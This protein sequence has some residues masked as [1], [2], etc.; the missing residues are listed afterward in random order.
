MTDL[1]QLSEA[2]RDGR[3]CVRCGS[4]AGA[5]RP[6]GWVR[7]VQVF[8][9]PDC[10]LRAH[11]QEMVDVGVGAVVARIEANRTCGDSAPARDVRHARSA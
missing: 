6:S 11:A 9:H 7:G 4:D 3:A 8:A 2:Q 10:E 1:A 5:M